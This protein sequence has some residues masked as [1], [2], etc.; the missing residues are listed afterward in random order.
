MNSISIADVMVVEISM[1]S[2]S[3][4][5]CIQQALFL[6][7]PIIAMKTNNRKEIF[8]GGAED[9]ESKLLVVEYDLSNLEK[10]LKQA[11]EYVHEWLDCRFTLILNNKIKGHLDNVAKTGTTRSEYIRKLVKTDMEKK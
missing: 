9:V 8:L 1:S 6:G 2:M 4:G 7:K 5:Q 11:L 3:I 10:V